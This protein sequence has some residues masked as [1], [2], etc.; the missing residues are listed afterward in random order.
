MCQDLIFQRVLEKKVYSKK[1]ATRFFKTEKGAYA[2]HDD[3]IGTKVPDLKKIAKEFCKA[4]LKCLSA[5]LDSPYNEIR[6]VALFILRSQYEKALNEDKS[7]II[8][9]YLQKIKQINNWNLVDSS[10]YPIL[11]SYLYNK[12]KKILYELAKSP[13]LFERRIAIVSTLFFI[14]KGHLDTTF[15][16][17]LILFED[18]HDLTHKA[19]GWMLRE[20][21]KI[22]KITTLNFLSTHLKNIPKTTLRY[23]LERLSKE[24]KKHL[25]P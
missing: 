18:P 24:E 1:E 7:K 9:F 8:D 23:A 22:D 11:G 5:L 4:D 12:D 20:A 2:E 19:T 25:L 10:S 3:F 13:H 14:K 16:L 21:M 15:N 17:A 6:L